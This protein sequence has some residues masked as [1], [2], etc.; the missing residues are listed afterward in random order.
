M[1]CCVNIERDTC[2]CGYH[3]NLNNWQCRIPTLNKLLYVSCFSWRKWYVFLRVDE[4]CDRNI[5]NV[6]S[7]WLVFY[8]ACNSPRFQFIYQYMANS[9]GILT[10]QF[11]IVL[12]S[13]YCDFCTMKVAHWWIHIWSPIFTQNSISPTSTSLISVLFTL[14]DSKNVQFLEICQ[15][16]CLWISSWPHISIQILTLWSFTILSISTTKQKNYRKVKKLC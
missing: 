3:I 7:F 11:V 5:S 12:K 14:S 16:F 6:F 13:S 2:V 8:L 15:L 9:P 10:S 4:I 1:G